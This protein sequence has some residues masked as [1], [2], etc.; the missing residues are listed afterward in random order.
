MMLRLM[1][2]LL[3]PT[4]KRTTELLQMPVMPRLMMLRPTRTKRMM[5]PQVLLE[6]KRLS[7]ASE[8]YSCLALTRLTLIEIE[9]LNSLC[10][11]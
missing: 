5:A 3:Q 8:Q 9:I 2:E 6:P 7:E 10:F 1:M 11:S 4:T